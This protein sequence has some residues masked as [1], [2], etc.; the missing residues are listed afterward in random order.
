MS[1]DLLLLWGWGLVPAVVQK[2]QILDSFSWGGEGYLVP[3]SPCHINRTGSPQDESVP[4][5]YVP[6][7]R[8]GSPTDESVLGS[9]CSVSRTGS[10]Q[11]VS[12]PVFYVPLS[13]TGS[14][15][16]ESVPGSLGPS[17]P[18]WV[19]SGRISS[20]IIRSLSAALGHLRKNQF[21]DH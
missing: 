12:V 2:R 14:P 3:G 5:F 1:C 18:H 20:R 9:L 8:T 7:S 21:Q 10:L 4:G 15:Q 17:Q 11:D 16:E 19:T 6:L 13:R